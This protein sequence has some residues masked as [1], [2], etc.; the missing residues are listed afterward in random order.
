M[1]KKFNNNFAKNVIIF[2]GDGMSMAT[3]TAARIYSGQ[4]NGHTGE[5]SKL[6]FEGFPALGHS[7]VSF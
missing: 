2:L 5:E 6:Y 4:L 3:I 1:R 7:K